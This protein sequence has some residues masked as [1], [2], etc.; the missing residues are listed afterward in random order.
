MISILSLEHEIDLCDSLPEAIE[1]LRYENAHPGAVLEDYQAYELA[2]KTRQAN[3]LFS[4]GLTYGRKGAGNFQATT[5]LALQHYW[6]Y[7]DSK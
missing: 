3:K 7:F 1:Y 2:R 6:N 5:Y 4:F